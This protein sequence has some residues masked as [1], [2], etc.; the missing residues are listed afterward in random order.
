MR[1]LRVSQRWH[2]HLRGLALRGE[3]SGQVVRQK[4]RKI[5]L[6]EHADAALL[7]RGLATLIASWETSA[8]TAP[9]AEVRHAPGVT[10][11]IF[12]HGPE[13]AV[14]NNAL[15]AGGLPAA[16]RSAALET[17]AA[18]YTDAGVPHYATRVRDTETALCGE[19]VQRAYSVDSTMRV[20]G[21]PLSSLPLPGPELAAET[22]PWDEYARKFG[23]PSD[24]LAHVDQSRLH[25]LT[26]RLG[27]ETVAAARVFDHDGNCGIYDVETLEHTRRRGLGTALTL[28]QL[29]DAATRG[30]QTASL[31]ATQMA[32]RVCA[33]VGFRELGRILENVPNVNL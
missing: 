6:P 18:A 3:G 4:R 21:M 29:H 15:D 20:M 12:P 22:L 24:F 25:L 13:R 2:R 26:A 27:G 19:L 30:C 23:L 14:S 32:E 11:A 17:M 16:E 10:G 28:H 31:Q 8:D 7:Q 33:T 1:K 9:G 5:A